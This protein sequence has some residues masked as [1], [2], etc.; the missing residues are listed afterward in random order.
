MNSLIS[1]IETIVEKACRSKKNTFGYSAWTHHIAK[2]VTFSKQLADMMHADSEVV[3]LAALLHDYAS[4]INKD[5]YQDHHVH[6]AHL[7]QQLLEKYNYPQEKIEQIEHCILSHRASKNIKRETIEAEII[8]S[9]DAMAHFTNIP[10]LFS[11]AYTVKGL[12]TEEGKVFVMEK[13]ERSWKKLLPEA[14]EII[15]PQ[16]RAAKMLFNNH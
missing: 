9:A 15:K 16:Y 8:A 7:A 13:L 10:S 6:G 1:N 12:E 2:V 3:E 5:F 11:L 4:I 14:K